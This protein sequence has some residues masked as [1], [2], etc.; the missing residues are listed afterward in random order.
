MKQYVAC[1]FLKYILYIHTLDKTGKVHTKILQWLSICSR[2]SD[3]YLLFVNQFF[4]SKFP[5]ELLQK[6]IAERDL[7]EDY[8]NLINSLKSD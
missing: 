4:F 7:G 6:I 8:G 5:N 1:P 3:F 2:I